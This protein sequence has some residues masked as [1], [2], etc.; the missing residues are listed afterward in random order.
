MLSRYIQQTNFPTGKTIALVDESYRCLVAHLGAA[1]VLPLQSLLSYPHFSSLF[2]SSDIIL[3]ESFFLTNRFETVKYIIDLCVKNEKKLICNLGG[4][5]IFKVVP[6]EI[7]FL[8][9]H[10]HI[11]IGNLKEFIALKNLLGYQCI[12]LM[13]E[14]LIKNEHFAAKVVIITNGPE[15][16]KCF[17]GNQ[18]EVFKPTLLPQREIVDTTGAGDAFIGGFLAGLSTAKS[19]P[20]CMQIGFYSA[21]NILKQRGCSVPKY[22]SRIL[23][24]L[25]S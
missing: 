9:E 12:E 16:A 13:A 23:T 17:H 1:E 7:K 15:P 10:S 2:E 8:I 22:I 11:I 5:Y 20:E 6:K 21:E 24:E 4:E 19:I 25:S 18:M 14:N 3:I